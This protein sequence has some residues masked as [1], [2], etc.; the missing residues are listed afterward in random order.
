[1]GK[2]RLVLADE[3][4]G[5]LDGPTGSAVVSALRE[6]AK[7]EGAAVVIVTHDERLVLPGDR[8][9]RLRDGRVD[10]G[11]ETGPGNAVGTPGGGV[12]TLG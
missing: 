5:E 4:T 1:I 2:P 3:P 11:S 12:G 8:V 10:G 7:G 9:V 6:A